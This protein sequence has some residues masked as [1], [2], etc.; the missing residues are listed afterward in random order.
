MKRRKL[1]HIEHIVD[2]NIVYF[3]RVRGCFELKGLRSALN[4]VQRRHPALR[5]LLGEERGRFYYDYDAAPNIP[6]RVVRRSTDEDYRYECELELQRPFGNDNP[7]FRA[8]WLRGEQES[9]LLFATSHRICD[10]A[11][12]VILVQEILRC[13]C[14]STGVGVDTAQHAPP[15]ITCGTGK[16]EPGRFA[17]YEPV[18]RRDL[19]ADYRPPSVW[20]RNLT[21]RALNCVLGLIPES[22][23]LSENREHSLEW[24][25]N[26]S[27]SERLKQRCK[28]EEVSVH[29]MFLVALDRALPAVFGDRAPKWIEN[30]ID[31]RRGRFPALKDDMV[32]FA[33]GNFKLMTGQSPDEEFWARARTVREEIL[34]KVEQELLDLPRRIHFSEMLRPLSRGQIQTIVRLGDEMNMNGS[35]NRFA[36][37]N[38]G[39]LA[40]SESETPVQATD[41]RIYMHSLNVRALCLVTYTFNGE[42]R[43][44]CMGDEK[45]LDPHQA[46]TLQH[47]FMS[48]L[49]NALTHTNVRGDRLSHCAAEVK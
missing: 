28:Q 3:V 18:T 12:M 46:E 7:L 22:R 33:G 26:V 29:A 27:L 10:G 30:P 41:L 11:S 31:I 13:L 44:Y 37:S 23:R 48:M 16:L 38:L 15:G 49:E 21:A 43:F 25:A 1:S 6:L 36:F 35:W 8:T 34:V 14:E 2:G 20:K 39:N 5:V 17:P 4:R 9:D 42:M 47:S 32:F 19:I 40:V 45:C 24:R